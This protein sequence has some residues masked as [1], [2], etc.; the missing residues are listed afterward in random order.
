[1]SFGSTV[2][3]KPFSL[4]DPD[5]AIPNSPQM[6]IPAPL[7]LGSTLDEQQARF[8][9]RKVMNSFATT[10]TLL[11]AVMSKTIWSD[12]EQY[13]SAVK[14]LARY[15]STM[16][17]TMLELTGLGGSDS[18]RTADNAI[19]A[20]LVRETA[21]LSAAQFKKD[22][23]IPPEEMARMMFE[24]SQHA[25]PGRSSNTEFVDNNQISRTLSIQ[26][27]G[28]KAYRMLG[29]FYPPQLDGYLSD[30]ITAKKTREDMV[31]DM[32]GIAISLADKQ[33]EKMISSTKDG[34]LLGETDHRIAWQ[35][36]LRNVVNMMSNL[37]P[38]K[39]DGLLEGLMEMGED[40]N[41]FKRSSEQMAGSILANWSRNLVESTWSNLQ[42]FASSPSEN[43]KLEEKKGTHFAL[44]H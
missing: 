36:S 11:S 3:A 33:T 13:L 25:L 41:N 20:S 27:S 42:K 19:R 22:L 16:T 10:S 4:D 23:N 24:V 14:D 17:N 44:R 32:L 31:G 38:E 30:F 15:H 8:E 2:K 37:L 21:Y 34:Q 5:E 9:L 7:V 35:G 6:A 1:M 18:Q 39:R 29:V 28:I 12:P 26:A 43:S 40:R